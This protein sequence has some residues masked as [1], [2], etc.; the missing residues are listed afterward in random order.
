MICRDGAGKIEEYSHTLPP[1][2]RGNR[3]ADESFCRFDLPEAT[4]QAGVYIITANDE[5]KYIGECRNLS[6]RFG[7]GQYGYISNRNCHA[8]GQSTNCKINSLILKSGKANERVDVWFFRTSHRKQVEKDLQ[9]NHNPP[10]NGRMPVPKGEQGRARE[11]GMPMLTTETF[12]IA[13]KEKFRIAQE[14]GQESIRMSAR[15]LHR[16]LGGYPG[17]NHRMPVCCQI[18][19]KEMRDGDTLVEKPTKGKGATLMI[20]YLLP[21]PEQA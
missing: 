10:W 5:E 7:R 8:D 6:N 20:E 16:E 2:V 17:P 12:R 3:Y 13:L 14:D 18:M 19:K 1:G 4:A 21:R 15:V 11:A 9:V